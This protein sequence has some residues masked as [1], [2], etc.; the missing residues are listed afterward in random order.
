MTGRMRKLALDFGF[1]WLV[2]LQLLA[3]LMTDLGYLQR[4]ELGNAMV[5]GVMLSLQAT[6]TNGKVALWRTLPVTDREIGRARWWQM[7]GLPGLAIMLVMAAALALQELMPLGGSRRAMQPDAMALL[8]G[9][10]LQ[11]F[12][13]VFLTLFGLAVNFARLTRSPFAIAS[14]ILV[15]VPWL[16]LLPGIVPGLP[17]ETRML[18]LG[19]AGLVLA[20]ILYMTAPNWPQPVTQPMQLEI[21]GGSNRAVTSDR[22]GQGGWMALCGL[23]ML[24]P[25]LMLTMIL[26]VWITLVLALNP[27]RGT[28]LQ[29]QLIIPLI[30]ILQMTQFN[31][32]A[33]R[34]L[35]ILPGST[36]SLTAYL[37]LLPLILMA[38]AACGLSL[39]LEPWLTAATPRIDVVVLAAILF[40]GAL[41]L[42]AGLAVRQMAMALVLML[43]LALAPL[44]IFGWDYVPPP[45]HDERLLSGL[46]AS[47]ICGG[48]IW[49]Y[50]QIS[51]GTRVYRLQ[52]FVA[53]H[54]RGRD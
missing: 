23:A 12:Y 39:I 33:L 18:M 38:A 7:T 16:L 8:R 34:A 49:M 24:R 53:S 44:I 19:L 35:R 45:W 54:W 37:F 22:A 14:T 48:F 30:V 36:A 40:A 25:V 11:F 27:G 15:W 32:T 6:T 2:P 28:I 9:L 50:V 3:A 51:R 17:M 13:P 20:V 26:A 42:P 31:A 52:P 5:T 46:T 41:G 21:G 10:L 4:P 29:L 47:A 1:A 43:P